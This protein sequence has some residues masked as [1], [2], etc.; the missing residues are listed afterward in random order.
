[1]GSD[2]SFRAIISS[3]WNECLAPCGPFDPISFAYPNLSLDLASIFQEYTGNII[4]LGEANH[5]IQKL[6]PS[7]ISI[8]QMDAYLDQSFM[9][10]KGVPDLIDWCTSNDILFMINTTG[11]MGYFQRVFA[12]S[13]LPPVPILSAN[14][15]IRYP[16]LETDP[17]YMYDL[18][19]IQDKSKNT[20]AVVHSLVAPAKKVFLVGDSGG[21]GPHFEWGASQGAF[22]IGSMAKP[23]LK[24]FCQK[25]G[26]VIDSLFG[27]SYL[28]GEKRNLQKELLI[29][30]L[31]LSSVIEKTLDQ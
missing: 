16:H 31:E 17:R 22:L 26:I 1:M 21:D 2:H 29:D 28:H 8:D 15:M 9:T 27:V 11:M 18:L 4:S 3:D 7:P 12:K 24:E 6:L 25:K 19:E 30:F 23:S 20:E 5:K 10:Y 13:L 14:P